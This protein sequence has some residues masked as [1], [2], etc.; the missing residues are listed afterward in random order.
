MPIRIARLSICLLLSL[1]FAGLT[2]AQGNDKSDP[3]KPAP[4]K[5]DSNKP[6]PKKPE[7]KKPDSNKPDSNKPEPSKPAEKKA[8]PGDKAASKPESMKPSQ[9]E[10]KPGTTEKASTTDKAS[11]A[12]AMKD[13]AK[14]DSEKKDSAKQDSPSA[15]KAKPVEISGKGLVFTSP[16]EGDRNFD[17]MGEF[18]GEITT[19]GKDGQLLG[20]QVRP[21]GDDN[22]QAVSFLGGLPGE[23]KHNRDGTKLLGRRSG[24]FLVLSGGPWAVFVEP[25]HCTLI[26]SNGTQLGRLKRVRR[27]SP[28]LGAKPPKD[29]IVLFDGTH[30]DHF[31]NGQMTD[32]GLLI[33]GADLKPMFQDFDLHL[34]FR[35]PYM[36]QADGQKRGNSGVYLQSRYECQVLDSFAQDRLINGCGAIYTFRKPELNMCFPPLVWQ[37]YDIRFTAPRWA[38]DGSKIR[39][40]HITSWLNGVKVQDDVEVPNKTGHGQEEEPLLLP[41]KLQNH[42]DPVR[43][44]NVWLI[45][46]GLLTSDF[47]IKAMKVQT[48][49]PEQTTPPKADKPDAAKQ[50]KSN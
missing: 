24:N 22:F 12:P 14:K 19:D 1:S 8:A 28:T 29:A 20:L 25:E 34:E 17:L 44:R 21:I 6:E 43:F 15:A 16:P 23:E 33:E 26:D 18:V 7:P 48:S 32:D 10:P 2:M 27:E 4:T 46:R 41:T 38:S 49:S 13:A 31:T 5:S 35:L 30:I 40:A 47:P 11:N 9:A 37:T 42:K 45:D 36:P 50:A 39:N 3:A